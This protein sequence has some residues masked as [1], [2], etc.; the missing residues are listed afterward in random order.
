MRQVI[1]RGR[2]EDVADLVNDDLGGKGV[3]LPGA[4]ALNQRTAL[5]VLRRI[6]SDEITDGIYS[7]Q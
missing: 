5:L 7:I 4:D 6:I 3:L 1:V 2:G